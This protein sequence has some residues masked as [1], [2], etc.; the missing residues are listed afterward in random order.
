M[1]H[2]LSIKH[3]VAPPITRDSGLEI[4]KGED[5]GRSS[6]PTNEIT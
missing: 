6:E 3:F 4:P 1:D 2:F 5:K